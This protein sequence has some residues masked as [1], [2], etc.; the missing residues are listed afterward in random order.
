M[1]AK[2][3]LEL[4][5]ETIEGAFEG[6]LGLKLEDLT[7]GEGSVED[8]LTLAFMLVA[9][10]INALLKAGGELLGIDLLLNPTPWLSVVF[11]NLQMDLALG[12]IEVTLP[13][14]ISYTMGQIASEFA[15]A[16]N[17]YDGGYPPIEFVEKTFELTIN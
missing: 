5:I 15:V 7:A 14:V 9:S 8:I 11:P 3:G 4:I 16:Y 1:I 12:H 17:I 13:G 10:S 6:A 2:K